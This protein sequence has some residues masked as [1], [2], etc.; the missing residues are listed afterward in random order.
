MPINNKKSWSESVNKS[1][2]ARQKAFYLTI[3]LE[4]LL[5]EVHEQKAKRQQQLQEINSRL[6]ALQQKVEQFKQK[7]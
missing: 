1:V 7:A 4:R 2:K 5:V 3:R 6:D